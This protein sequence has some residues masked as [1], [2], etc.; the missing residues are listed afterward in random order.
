MLSG[1]NPANL[2]NSLGLPEDIGPFK[3]NSLSFTDLF[4]KAKN[5][6]ILLPNPV[7]TK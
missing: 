4:F 5:E 2:N 3:P 7:S 1:F 6:A